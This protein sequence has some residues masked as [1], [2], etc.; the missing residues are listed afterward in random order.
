MKIYLIGSMKNP[1]VI[2]VARILRNQKC[3]VFDDWYAPGPE[4]DDYWQ[5][6]AKQRGQSYQEALY[7]YHAQHVFD[8]DKHHLDAADIGI[9]I[10]PAGKSGHLELGYLAGQNKRTFVLFDQ[11]PDRYDIMYLFAERVV[12]SVDELLNYLRIS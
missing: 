10:M 3:T 9:L 7:D 1:K 12:F 6:Y 11:E 8:F 2:E 5:K 4:T